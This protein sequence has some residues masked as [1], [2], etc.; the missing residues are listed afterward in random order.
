MFVL[1]EASLVFVYAIVLA[2]RRLSLFSGT[3]GSVAV[4]VMFT[5]FNG[6][7][8]AAGPMVQSAGDESILHPVFPRRLGKTAVATVPANIAAAR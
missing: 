5:G 7:G 2:G 6:V 8:L 4:G 3:G 1:D